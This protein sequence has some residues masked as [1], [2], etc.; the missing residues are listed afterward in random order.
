MGCMDQGSCSGCP[1]HKM[2]GSKSQCVFLCE[3]GD[4]GVAHQA[5]KSVVKTGAIKN[6]GLYFEPY[7]VE[8]DMMSFPY[9]YIN[10]GVSGNCSIRKFLE[11]S[12]MK[13]SKKAC[14]EATVVA[15]GKKSCPRKPDS[16]PIHLK[17]ISA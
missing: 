17:A 2:I 9:S 5:F 15:G 8:L 16:N 12:L 1:S 10:E 4:G 11:I 13:K 14:F 3:F 6:I 7:L